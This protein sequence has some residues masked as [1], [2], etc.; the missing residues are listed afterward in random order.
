[1]LRRSLTTLLAAALAVTGLTPAGPSS[2]AESTFYLSGSLGPLA[3]GDRVASCD[4]PCLASGYAAATPVASD[5]SFAVVTAADGGRLAIWRD[6]THGGYWS[7]GGGVVT[8]YGSADDWP[9]MC[10][11]EPGSGCYV[12]APLTASTLPSITETRQDDLP[13]MTDVTMGIAWNSMGTLSWHGISAPAGTTMTTGLAPC[14][15]GQPDAHTPLVDAHS[16]TLTTSKKRTVTIADSTFLWPL[17]T[18]FVIR[19]A[20]PGYA[21][22]VL[23]QYDSYSD[24]RAEAKIAC[25]LA[26]KSTGRRLESWTWQGSIYGTMFDLIRDNTR[27]FLKVGDVQPFIP[28]STGSY[29]A[30]VHDAGLHWSYHFYWVS[31]TRTSVYKPIPTPAG[32]RLPIKAS[33]RHGDVVAMTVLRKKGYQTLVSV[34]SLPVT[35]YVDDDIVGR[36]PG[37]SGSAVSGK[38][39][40]VSAPVS[41]GDARLRTTYQWQLDGVSV[42]GATGRSYVIA[43]GDVGTTLTVKVHIVDVTKGDGP[44]GYY[45]Y[46]PVTKT[47]SAGVVTG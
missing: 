32:F 17:G 20:R 4:H 26:G 34:D 37:L 22:R 2:A 9:L 43:P 46:E 29:G 28:L 30:G 6:A 24:S 47:Y 7:A 3:A 21:T 11:D 40:K 5:G 18:W 42:R 16:V 33:Y 45:C 1:M 15:S 36:W 19:L 31:Q 27:G 41:K 12:D 39:V 10:A 8:A 23:S 13:P 35:P 38:T 14:V 44:N 25:K